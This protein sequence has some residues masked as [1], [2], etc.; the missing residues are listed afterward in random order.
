MRFFLL[1]ALAASMW[2]GT[3]AANCVIP[4]TSQP[5]VRDLLVDFS[6]HPFGGPSF[7]LRQPF[8]VEYKGA[9]TYRPRLPR[10][11]A[12]WGLHIIEHNVI[13]F[14]E[15]QPV[16]A[17]VAGAEV[18]FEVQGIDGPAF[19]INS[20]I[21]GV[22]ARSFTVPRFPDASL[23]LETTLVQSDT[24]RYW[25]LLVTGT[26]G[27]GQNGTV[28]DDLIW[29]RVAYDVRAGYSWD[30][31]II[32]LDPVAWR[33]EG[34]INFNGAV[35]QGDLD[36][37]LLHWGVLDQ[38]DLDRVLVRWGNELPPDFDGLAA[39][40]APEPA[41]WVLAAVA[42]GMAIFFRRLQ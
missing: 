6:I 10:R 34:D 33:C 4:F 32:R 12:S 27:G 13:G 39:A 41:A 9:L 18:E 3:A 15:P 35:E 40:G 37:V 8:L 24:D 17:F 30:Q 22:D 2:V 23:L 29:G 7:S 26:G 28:I 25:E 36:E 11:P 5:Q 20:L 21:E 31:R 38:D 14:F 16:K 1:A 42:I 19:E